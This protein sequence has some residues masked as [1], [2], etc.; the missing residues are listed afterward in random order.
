MPPAPKDVPKIEVKFILTPQSRL[1]VEVRD[2]DTGRQKEWLQRGA[3][4]LTVAGDASKAPCTQL[5]AA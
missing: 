2:L 1:L 5:A 4:T 3:V